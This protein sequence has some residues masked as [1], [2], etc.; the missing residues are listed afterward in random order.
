VLALDDAGIPA[1]HLLRLKGVAAAALD[2]RLDA[3]R[4]RGLPIGQAL[5]EL[6][7]LRGIGRWS[8]QHVVMRGSGLAD[9]MPSA[10]PRVAAAAA[11]AYD[12]RAPMDAAAMVALADGWRPY[13]MWVSVLLVATHGFSAE[14]RALAPRRR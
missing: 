8:A 11:I 7:R 2:G 13:R 14:A 5:A 4:I 12:A 6:E 10:E 9:A 3:E 1:E